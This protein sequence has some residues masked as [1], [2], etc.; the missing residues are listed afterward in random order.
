M[1]ANTYKLDF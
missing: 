1:T